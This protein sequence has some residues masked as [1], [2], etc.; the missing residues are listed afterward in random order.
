MAVSN[1]TVKQ[2]YNGNGSTDTFAIPFAFIASQASAQV[3]VYRI[4]NTTKLATLQVEGA[5]QDY[6]LTPAYDPVTNPNGPTNVVFN[7]GRIP[8]AA[9]KVLVIR[10][11]P[12]TQVISFISNTASLGA[13]N[14]EVGL[15]RAVLMIQQLYEQIQR[16]PSILQYD[17]MVV[18]FDPSIPAVE[19]EY[20]LRVNAA[21]TGFEFVSAAAVASGAGVGIPPGGDVGDF[22]QKDSAADGDATW[23]TGAISGFSARYNQN[24]NLAGLKE[25]IDFIMQITYTAPTIS[26]TASGSTTIREKGAPVTATT[27]TATVTKR[28]DPIATVR[29]YLNPSTLLDT[30]TSGGA[31][32]N[33]GSSTYNWTG[34][35]SDNTT[36]RGEADDDGA[37][38]GPTTVSASASFTFVYPYYFG[39][40]APALTAAQVALL[41]KDI[42][43]ST[44]SLLKTFTPTTGQVFYFAYPASYGALTSILDQNGFQ[45]IGDWTLR[46]ENITGLD[47]TAQSYRIYVFNNPVVAGTYDYTFI[48]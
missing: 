27:L 47:T 46:T 19:P 42:R 36:F 9:Q 23:R 22:I 4:D 28:S 31:I 12:Y 48:R 40:G 33:G 6:T 25:T 30:Q 34:S 29:F 35:F 10:E 13:N 20:L 45:T 11:V 7:A 39:S 16:A 38:G 26:F 37:T 2:L 1:T 3:K 21:G 43:V 5:L 18:N 24:V 41:T 14:L 44:A 8:T 15:D 17:D 32:P